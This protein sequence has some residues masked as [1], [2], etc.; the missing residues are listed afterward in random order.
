MVKSGTV[1][2]PRVPLFSKVTIARVLAAI[3]VPEIRVQ[4]LVVDRVIL[5][6]DRL[7]RRGGNVLTVVDFIADE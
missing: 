2:Y 1:W 6:D 7:D 3:F 5:D 4:D